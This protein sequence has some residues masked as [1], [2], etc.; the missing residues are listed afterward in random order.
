MRIKG[1]YAA[2]VIIDIDVDAEK[3]GLPFDKIHKNITEG[4]TPA[5]R[6]EL[7]SQLDGSIKGCTLELIQQ[8]A[9]V[10]EAEEE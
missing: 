5:L 2:Q 3:T 9:D 4:L 7:Q 1:R 6:E 8:Y 10:W